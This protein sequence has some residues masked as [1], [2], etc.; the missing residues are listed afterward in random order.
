MIENSILLVT[1]FLILFISLAVLVKSSDVVS[2][3][4]SNIAQITGIGQ[5]AIG[6]LMLSIITSLPELAIA[7]FSVQCGDTGIA[8]GTLF[9]S[10]IANI[11]LVLGITAV[12][13]TT[14]MVISQNSLKKLALMMF[15]PTLIPIMILLSPEAW[16]ITGVILLGTFALFCFYIVRSKTT[17]GVPKKKITSRRTIAK[18]LGIIVACLVAIII[19]ANYVVDSAIKIATTFRIDKLVIGATIVAVGTSLP[20]LSVTLAAARKKHMD[21]ALGNILGSCF[22][23]LTLILGFS[24]VASACPV[25]TTIFFELIIILSIINL[26][27]WRMLADSK[28]SFMDGFV[29]IFLYLIFLGSTIGVQLFILTP[30][31]ISYTLA[32]SGVISAQIFGA[33]IILIVAIILGFYL[34]RDIPIKNII[35]KRLAATRPKY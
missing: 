10:N 30:E 27:L 20:E 17:T 9:G 13:S 31:N 26:A 15:A 6:F 16:R 1:Q 22:T 12:V 29:L 21:L 35:Q 24:L 33:S 11:G 8:V 32:V 7:I 23:N 28:I 2:D 19:S 34:T 4:A 18:D 3:S 14:T 5:L 25:N